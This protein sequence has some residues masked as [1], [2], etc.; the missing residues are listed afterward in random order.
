MW[1][2]SEP[3]PERFVLESSTAWLYC[4]DV[5]AK[6]EQTNWHHVHL[7]ERHRRLKNQCSSLGTHRSEFGLFVSGLKWIEVSL[8]LVYKKQKKRFE[9]LVL[10]NAECEDL[11]HG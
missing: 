5:P 4:R 7:V 1:R 6:Q 11:R 9:Y 8:V 3:G 2:I 10:N